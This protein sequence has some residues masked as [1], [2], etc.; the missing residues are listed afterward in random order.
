MGNEERG[1]VLEGE[2]GVVRAI[3][4]VGVEVEDGFTVGEGDDNHGFWWACAE[5]D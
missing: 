2:G 3:E 1:E 5:E 4:W